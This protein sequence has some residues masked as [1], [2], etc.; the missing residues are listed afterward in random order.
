MTVLRGSR[1][2][3]IL[4]TLRLTSVV[5]VVLNMYLYT[6]Y[7]AINDEWGSYNL[8]SRNDTLYPLLQFGNGAIGIATLLFF[9]V[10]DL[11][12]SVLMASL[13]RSNPVLCR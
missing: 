4:Q 6:H 2:Y 5:S 3:T 12:T 1:E 13:H 10:V 9:G 7:V 11:T 8:A